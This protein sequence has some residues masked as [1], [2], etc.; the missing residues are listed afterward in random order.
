MTSVI[1]YTPPGGA[2]FEVTTRTLQARHLL[3]PSAEANELIVGVLGRAQ[4]LYPIEL[5]G[6]V[7]LSNHYHL[8]ARTPDAERLARF[9]CYANGNLA[10]E[11]GRLHDWREKFWSRRYTAILVSDE[12]RAQVARLKYLLSNGAKEGLVEKPQDWPGVHCAD[13]LLTGQPLRGTWFNRT[14]EYYARLRHQRFDPYAYAEVQE[15]HFTKLPCWSHLSDTQYRQRIADLLTEIEQ[16]AA[17]MR[18]QEGI[19]LRA[20]R[21]MR[22]ALQRIDPHS[23]PE[24]PKRSPPPK[25]HAA[26][27][28]VRQEL[29]EAYGWFVTQY[30]AAADELRR[31]NRNA[32]FPEGSFPPG[33]PFVRP[34]PARGP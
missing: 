34:E 9:M 20:R 3:R 29:I 1:R 23:A 13:S 4:K 5:I 31:G 28:R 17:E 6:A 7:F 11:L 30:R 22:R 19:T 14:Q 2:L 26:S 16:E 15:I 27:K 12:E 32:L 18:Q 25:V 21:K 24:E 33:L 8:L 10:R